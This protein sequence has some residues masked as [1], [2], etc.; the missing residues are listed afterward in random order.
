MV[1]RMRAQLIYCRHAEVADGLL[2]ISGGGLT[3]RGPLPM[4]MMVACLVEIGW[5][6]TNIKHTFLCSIVDADGQ[7]VEAG[8]GADGE[9]FKLV[10]N[11]GLELGRPAGVL[12]GSALSAPIVCRFDGVP[13]EPGRYQFVFEVDGER[14]A[15]Y[16]FSVIAQDVP[17]AV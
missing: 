6:E 14:L 15:D 1:P 7:P 10:L 16:P 11:G 9:P 4:T 2:F 17:A 13:L 12:S 5:Q 3:W 8:M